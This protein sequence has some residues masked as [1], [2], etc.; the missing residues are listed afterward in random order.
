M[1]IYILD[2]D[3]NILF[4]LKQIILSRGLGEVAGTGSEPIPALTEITKL[5][6]DI[7]LIDLLM[8]ELDGLAVIKQLRERSLA[9]SYIM[10]SQ[11]SSKDLIARA[12]EAGI[13]FYIQK[14]I[15]AV[16]VE[17][18]IKNVIEKRQVMST[19]N[20][21]KDMFAG[22]PPLPRPEAGTTPAAGPLPVTAPAAAL[23]GILQ[24]LGIIGDLGSRDI[25]SI[26]SYMLEHQLYLGDVTLN[27]VCARLTTTPKSM[28]QRVRRTATNGLVHLAHLGLE[29]FANPIFEEY[30]NTVYSFSQVRKE[31]D[32]IKGHSTSHGYVKIRNFLNALVT[33]CQNK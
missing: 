6:P 22:N 7:V 18:V 31:M 21:I 24:K 32:F 15:N 28:E 13:E 26:V 14:P 27:E 12:Y 17:A 10:L 30:A 5:K 8:P 2:D 9:A 3:P 29:D 23:T 1:N 11:V 20:K 4:L 19:Y 16:E 25:H 33:Y